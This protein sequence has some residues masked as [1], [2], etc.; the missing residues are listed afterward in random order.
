MSRRA[1]L[2]ALAVLI[3]AAV[4]GCGSQSTDRQQPTSR[5]LA[6]RGS[7]VGK[8]VL[9]PLGA[10]RLDLRTTS[11]HAAADLVTVPASAIVYDS[12]GKTLIF[13]RHGRLTFTESRVDV[14]H[15]NGNVAYLRGGPRGGTAVVTLGAEELFGVESGV[16]EQT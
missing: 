15:I 11:V 7:S 6:V 14:D 12:T 16:L 13:T 2:T 4:A 5:L 1:P 3:A 9:T 10:R 8:I